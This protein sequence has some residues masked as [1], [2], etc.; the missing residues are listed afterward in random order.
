[1]KIAGGSY[2]E[3]CQ[4]PQWDALFGSG[5]RAAAALS[6]LSPGT[7]LYTYGPE[8]W[9]N[10]IAASAG[11]FSFNAFVH[12][13]PDE[14][15]FHYFHPLSRVMIL[16]QQRQSA[17]TFVVEGDVV[18]RFG[19]LEGDAIVHARAAIYDP[20]TGAEPP[21]FRDNG[22]TVDRLAVVLNEWEAELATGVGGHASGPALLEREE[23]EVAI[24]K[25]GPRGA[26]VHQVG[27]PPVLV[28]PYRTEKVFK[29][30]SGDIFSAAFAYYWAERGFDPVSAADAASRSASHFVSGPNLPLPD[31]DG[32]KVGPPMIAGASPRKVYLAGPFF[33]LSQRWL[34]DETLDC[35]ERLDLEVFSPLHDVGAGGGARRIA[36]ADLAGLSEC[37]VVLA[38]LDGIDTGTVFETGH[39]TAMGKR[40]VGLAERVEPY[41][42]T[43]LEGT[44]ARITRDFTTALYMAAWEAWEA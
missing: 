17:P 36:P 12:P 26:M 3:V 37:G 30:G 7:E 28:P 1:M 19:F 20:Q 32:L 35:L 31:V 23:A 10:D 14:I 42:L 4:H 6:S 5:L 34:I 18:L 38:L 13:S 22:S 43:M 33:H 29:I 15:A 40:I 16:P 24:I 25:S 8:T 2:R 9:R 39:A 44:G 21:R 27:R 41:Q 11:A